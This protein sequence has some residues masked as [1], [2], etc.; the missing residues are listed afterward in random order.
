MQQ[1][2]ESTP[3]ISNAPK[4]KLFFYIDRE[5][6]VFEFWTFQHIVIVI[7]ERH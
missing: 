5:Q 3:D 2:A 1:S 6:T 7:C 4:A